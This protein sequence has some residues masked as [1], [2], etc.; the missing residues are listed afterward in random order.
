M[1]NIDRKNGGRGWQYKMTV[2][3]E[4]TKSGGEKNTGVEGEMVGEQ[5]RYL[6]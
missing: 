4:E 1:E 6:Y 5:E 3:E 2:W